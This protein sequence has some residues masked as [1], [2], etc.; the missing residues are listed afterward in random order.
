MQMSVVVSRRNFVRLAGGGLAVSAMALL[1]A[2]GQAA[3]PQPTAASVP[4]T[5]APVAKPTTAA[6]ATVAPAAQPQPTTASAAKLAAQAG[7]VPGQL[8]ISKSLA[9]PSRI[10]IPGAK[11][12]LVGSDDGLVDPGYINY[13][14]NPF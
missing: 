3:T 8:P 9:M 2:C 10:P 6:A 5:A 1:Q 7:M 4:P 14:A 11:P 12:D 13:P